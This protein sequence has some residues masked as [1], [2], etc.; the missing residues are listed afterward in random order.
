[1]GKILTQVTQYIIITY[2]IKLLVL[3][4][5]L[6][7]SEEGQYGKKRNYYQNGYPECSL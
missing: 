4:A 2:V 3:L 1:M 7:I 6:Y 5:I